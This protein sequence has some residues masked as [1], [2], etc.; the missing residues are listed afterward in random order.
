MNIQREQLIQAWLTTVLCSDQFKIKYLAGDASFRRYARVYFEEKSFILMDAPPEQEDC[1]PFVSIDEYLDQHD[2]RVPHIEAKDLVLGVLLLED[3]GDI[4]LAKNLNQHSVDPYYQQCFLQLLQLQAI[5][6]NHLFPTYS[7]EKLWAE[8]ELFNAWTLPSL[9]IQF[10]ESAQ[11]IVKH[12]FQALVDN[13]IMQPQVIVHRDFHSRNLMVLEHEQQLGVI[14]FQDAVVGPDTYDLISLVRD[15][16]VQ[17]DEPRVIDW[18]TEFYE[19]L[20]ASS[21]ANRSLAQFIQDADFI[22]LQRHIKILGIFVRLYERDGKQNYLAD[23]PLVMWYVVQI[24]QKYPELHDF[25]LLL[26][27]YVLPKFYAKYGQ[28]KV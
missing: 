9:G 26:E 14:D 7:H 19:L 22:S 11:A 27:Q 6:P 24:S 13:A 8:M 18:I 10:D 25:Y 2:V 20:P 17:W 16:Y 12:A 5:E 28:Y 4:V 15:A 1:I 23:L 3:F 21:K